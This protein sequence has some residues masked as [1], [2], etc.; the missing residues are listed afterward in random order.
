MPQQ[1]K[2]MSSLDINPLCKKPLQALSNVATCQ[3]NAQLNSS[4]QQ[5]HDK[6]DLTNTFL[7]YPRCY[8]GSTLQHS[9]VIRT[10]LH[11][12]PNMWKCQPFSCPQYMLPFQAA[13]A[14]ES[15]FSICHQ[16]SQLTCSLHKGVMCPCQDLN[17]AVMCSQLVYLSKKFQYILLTEKCRIFTGHSILHTAYFTLHT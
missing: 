8:L 13:A 16:D 3:Q 4:I 9:Y 15:N 7:Y 11:A 17:L 5:G 10:L 12:A 1:R 2:T 14:V 6:S